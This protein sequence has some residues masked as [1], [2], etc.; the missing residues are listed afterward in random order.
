MERRESNFEELVS[1]IK[2]IYSILAIICLNNK[3]NQALSYKYAVIYIED[4]F[5]NYGSE[6]LLIQTFKN[7]YNLLCRVSKPL[8]NM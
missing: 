1:V 6:E 8:I 7:N 5:F 4:I 3:S 2:K